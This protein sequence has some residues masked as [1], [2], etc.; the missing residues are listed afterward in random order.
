M[1]SGIIKKWCSFA[2]LWLCIWALCISIAQPILAAPVVTSYTPLIDVNE[3]TS[4]TLSLQYENEPLSGMSF[5][6]YRT[7]DVSAKAKFTPTSHFANYAVSFDELDSESW[8]SLA[9]TLAGYAARDKI[10]ADAKSQTNS[11]GNI[12]F[13]DLPVGLYLVVGEKQTQNGFVYT[14]QPFLICL[15]NLETEDQWTYA[16][17][18][19][20]KFE[21]KDAPSE[22]KTT[23]RRVLK[24][25]KNDDASEARPNAVVMQ[26]LKDGSVFEEVTLNAKNDWGHTWSDLDASFDWN[27]VE[28]EVPT[29]YTVQTEREENT[30]VITNTYHREGEDLPSD[31]TPTDTDTSQPSDNQ[32]DTELPQTGQLWWPVPLL[33][34]AG[35]LLFLT[36]WLISRKKKSC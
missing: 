13:V 7:A 20:P 27:V 33:A 2:A 36:G 23:E 21:R 11:D 26:L 18:A 3:K 17:V 8:H 32:E 16:V 10:A 4:L 22:P 29:G 15:P 25:W 1:K 30:F 35:L 34:G 14:P 24:I 31:P 6:L 28:K 19:E 9:L 12:K 5:S